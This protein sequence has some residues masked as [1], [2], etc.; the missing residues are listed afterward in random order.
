MSVS[1]FGD[2]QKL[3]G[4]DPGQQGL[5]REAGQDDL[6]SCASLTA[7]S[8][9]AEIHRSNGSLTPARIK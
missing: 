2:T 6:Q 3:S 1:I 8:Q 5:G 7:E 9:T 4:H